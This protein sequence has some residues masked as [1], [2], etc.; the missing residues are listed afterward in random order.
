MKTVILGALI[1]L[2]FGFGQIQNNKSTESDFDCVLTTSKQVYSLGEVPEFQVSIVNNSGE[3]VYLIGSLDGSE[4]QW[5]M[6]FC[7]FSLEKPQVDSVR[8]IM[9]CGMTN[10]LRMKDFVKI[11]AGQFFNPYGG[12]DDFSFSHSFE[13]QR[14]EH[15]RNTGTYKITFHYSTNSEKIE[16]YLGI[17]FREEMENLGKMKRLF[18]QVP[19]I[20]LQSNTVEIDIVE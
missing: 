10:N 1:A 7:Y 3:D 18:K 19:K 8:Q 6:P 15:F 13:M 9:R 5:R 14:K 17:G 2:C 12:V 16:D 11:E 4:V 20:E